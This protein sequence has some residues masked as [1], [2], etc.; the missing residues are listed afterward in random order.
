[1]TF[2]L[3][4]SVALDRDLPER[5]LKSGDLGAVVHVYDADAFEVE[6][7]DASGGTA[8]VLTLR[9]SDLRSVDAGDV[10]AVRRLGKSA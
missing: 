7:V 8:A 9:S 5:G 2:E 6:F 1:M 10:L 4:D 3:H